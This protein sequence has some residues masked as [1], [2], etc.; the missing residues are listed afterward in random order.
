MGIHMK[1]GRKMGN[2]HNCFKPK[3]LEILLMENVTLISILSTAL[4]ITT[5]GTMMLAVISYI[6]FRVKD[7]KHNKA[8][9]TKFDNVIKEAKK[10]GA[11]LDDFYKIPMPGLGHKIKYKTA[12]LPK[13]KRPKFTVVRQLTSTKAENT[14]ESISKPNKIRW[15]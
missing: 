11:S 13:P 1:S 10:T 2:I 8:V 7:A 9:K 14:V 15:K 3:Q 6:L 5:I 12:E 4:L